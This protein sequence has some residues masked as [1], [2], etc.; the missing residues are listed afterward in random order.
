M[1][2]V[3][4][5]KQQGDPVA[6]LIAKLKLENNHIVLRLED[7]F[8]QDDEEEEEE[9]SD[10]DE[11][12]A[13]GDSGGEDSGGGGSDMEEDS[14]GV[15]AQQRKARKPQY[16]LV[17]VDLELSAFANARKVRWPREGGLEER[18][19]DW[20][21]GREKYTRDRKKGRARD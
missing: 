5:A 10:A 20:K 11:G 8:A 18:A 21:R 19:R 15:P 12:A 7:I 14:E 6:S 2:Q 17:E 1:V 9:V 13:S 3:D 16:M 4:E